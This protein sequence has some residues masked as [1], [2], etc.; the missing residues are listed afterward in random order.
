MFC[1]WN[2]RLY[3]NDCTNSCS[4]F[5]LAAADGGTESSA[6][7][8]DNGSEEDYSYEELCQA[9]PRYLQPGGEQ[10]AINE[11]TSWA[12]SCC[13]V[14]LHC[15]WDGVHVFL[16]PEIFIN[17]K[18]NDCRHHDEV[19]SSSGIL[20]LTASQSRCQGKRMLTSTLLRPLI[21]I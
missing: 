8:D 7:V 12:A 15:C 17:K 4:T 19:S 11:V 20:P 21:A 6:L 3:K 18:S 14:S 2:R 13:G 5:V 1:F 10:L 9:T 16:R